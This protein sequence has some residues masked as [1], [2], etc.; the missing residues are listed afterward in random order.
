MRQFVKYWPLFLIAACG[1]GSRGS[2][3]PAA[4]SAPAVDKYV[5]MPR[6]AAQTW[7]R[8]PAMCGQGPY[9]L[10]LPVGAA[11]YGEEVEL[12]AS[13]PRAIALHAVVMVGDQELETVEGT[14][15]R[16]G[17]TSGRADNARCLADAK[18]RLAID[19]AR[20]SGGG[21]TGTPGAPGTPVPVG[22]LPPGPAATVNAELVPTT[23]V[24]DTFSVIH[25]RVPEEARATGNVRIKLWS[26]E[27]ND[28]EGVVFGLAHVV[29]Q[30]GVS[31]AEYEA[32]LALVAQQQREAE[33]RERLAREE[34]MRLERERQERL[35]RERQARAKA[36][37][38]V[39]VD[40]E[41]ARRMREQYEREWEEQR[42]RD[43]ALA[44]ARRKR[45]EAD[46]LELERQRR[47]AALAAERRKQ[48]CASH[49]EDR[50]C[51][52]V[53]G[54]KV[55]LEFEAHVAEREAYCK[56]HH[57]DARCW[58]I[59]KKNQIGVEA[60]K[61]ITA[62]LEPAKPSGPPPDPLAEEQPPKLSVHAEWRPGY[63]QWI[64]GT[65][66]WLAGMWRVPEEDIVSE[67][68]TTAPAAPPP[69]RVEAPPPQP[70][71]T[72]VWIEG[73]WQWNGTSW[74]WIPGSWQ[75]RPSA[76]MTWRA[77]TWQPRGS[78]HVL[79]PGAWVRIGGR[80]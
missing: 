42:R 30:P 7:Y 41:A 33:E 25:I 54:L 3:V 40:P 68:T 62:A 14:F 66:V 79:V 58:T 39:T 8:A 12:V 67:Q 28:L 16:L 22:V 32:H 63:W 35:E 55:H 36:T 80:R 23:A 24:V 74:I 73:F 13:T 1:G 71:R 48:F 10:V 4:P 51:W 26:I 27:P 60:Q 75:L 34:R 78:V 38:E 6:V 46:R 65:W 61:R 21:G 52:G 57:E 72:A 47:E 50:G 2:A 56:Q 43:A 29:W 20:R 9:Q 69:I 5:L 59:V 18:E 31:D 11:K 15:D 70:V 53:G 76:S 17:R 44:E 49:P 19:R 64:D 45:M 37:V 77:A